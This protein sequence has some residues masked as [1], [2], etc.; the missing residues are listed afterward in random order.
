M[1]TKIAAVERK[2]GLE[3][4]FTAALEKHTDNS[5]SPNNPNVDAKDIAH[6]DDNPFEYIPN[7]PNNPNSP[8]LRRSLSSGNNPDNP[9]SPDKP[10]N[11][12]ENVPTLRRSVSS[13]LWEKIPNNLRKMSITQSLA[14][15]RDRARSR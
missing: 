5:N 6:P 7:S 12:G 2:L 11:P 8:P 14:K 10:D 9:D 15:A 3:L 4:G 13:S 1:F